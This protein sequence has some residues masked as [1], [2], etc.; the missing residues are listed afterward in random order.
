MRR[1]FPKAAALAFSIIT[2]IAAPSLAPAQ[3]PG[4]GA[5]RHGAALM[6]EPR[7]APGFEHFDYV[8]PD[9]PKDGTVRLGAL[10]S[11]DNF[12]PI[13]AGVRGDLG[14][15]LGLIYETLMTEALDEPSTSYGLIAEA[16]RFPDDYSS[17]TFRLDPDARWHD[18]TPISARDVIWSFET[19]KAAN[20]LY[21]T[22]YANV[23]SAEETAPGEVTFSFDVTGNRE[24]PKIMGQ[25]LVLPEHW[26]TAE[27]RAPDETTLEPPLGSGPYRLAEYVPG[28]SIVY[29]RVPD[30]WSID[31][32]TNVGKYNFDEVRYEY[33]RDATVLLEAFKADQVDFRSE[34]V[35]RNWATAYDFPAREE[36]RVVLETFP[37]LSTGRM[38]AFTPNL[39]QER[40]Q[41]A[42]VRRALNLAFD[43]EDIN[44]TIF[45]GS[46]ER[47][48]SFFEG[49]ELASSG[50]PEGRELEILEEYRGQ[51]PESVFTEPYT[52]P[53]SPDA[54]ARR[55]N[56]READ[57]LLR[58]A[59]W[60]VEEG[61]RVNAETG[62]PFDIEF[63]GFQPTDE[64]YALPYAQALERLGIRL[65]VRIVDPAQYQ[66][67]VRSF[68]FDMT[69]SL[70]PQTLSPGNEQ[71][72]MWGSRAAEIPGS[73]NYA[74]IA[75]P[76]VDALIERVVFAQDREE[77]VAATRALDRVLLHNDYVIPQWYLGDQR[78]ARW[79]RFSH[80]E[81]MPL[82]A[83]SA[84]PTVWWYDG[85]KARETG[86][87]R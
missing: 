57:R 5:W 82:Y 36:G 71:R 79:N 15:G 61:R 46:Y 50:L 14:A 13:V 73:Q 35:A 63:L 42:R 38:Q 10:G 62:E 22:Y 9:A 45:F 87:V 43:F 75:D 80:P 23:V 52:N 55:E 7:Y 84:F 83:A 17:V 27:G 25:L 24:L 21:M 34:N 53:T 33:F 39:R 66:N 68:D 86:A 28:R 58:E 20:P 41:D 4:A 18:G 67:R 74:G 44:R 56:L 3:E 51:I 6:G 1:R 54:Q 70:W 48:D 47:I 29:E 81:T 40:F 49:L 12:N 77:L 78:T 11:F 2:T 19:L 32:P 8:N 65:D 60:V 59:G 72:D 26:F 30:A 85:E 69:T 76:A 37:I 64:R 16:M 31:H